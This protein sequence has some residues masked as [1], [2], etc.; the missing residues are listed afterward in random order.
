MTNCYFCHRPVFDQDV[1]ISI[2]DPLITPLIVTDRDGIDRPM[3]FDL[4]EHY[5]HSD[6]LQSAA[7][8]FHPQEQHAQASA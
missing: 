4:L 1:Q 5:A 2:R 7:R 8:N 6:C 3:R